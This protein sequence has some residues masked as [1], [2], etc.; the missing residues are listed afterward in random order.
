[1]TI[2][3]RRMSKVSLA[4]AMSVK[5][6]P[7]FTGSASSSARRAEAHALAVTIAVYWMSTQNIMDYIQ[8]DLIMSAVPHGVAVL[9]GILA[10]TRLTRVTGADM[11]FEM[12]DHELEV[13]PASLTLP[14]GE[15]GA[16]V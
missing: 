14:R 10:N 5:A 16:K 15:G 9:V 8:A 11:L 6:T 12:L 4:S 1:M 13:R 2:L 7:F 3:L